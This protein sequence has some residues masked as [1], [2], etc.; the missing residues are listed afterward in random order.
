M[1]VTVNI[2][3]L[4]FELWALLMI[5]L[6]LIDKT[7]KKVVKEQIG[8]MYKGAISVPKKAKEINAT[9][10]AP[11]VE[12]VSPEDEYRMEQERR[13]KDGIRY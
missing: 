8:N 9:V 2:Y 3:F 10:N 12:Y 13:E 6:I 7:M 4:V 5:S 11:T 1:M